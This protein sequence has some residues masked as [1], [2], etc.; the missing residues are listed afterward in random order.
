MS[1]SRKAY[2]YGQGQLARRSF[3]DS[4]RMSTVAKTIAKRSPTIAERSDCVPNLS[5]NDQSLFLA[6]V[7]LTFANVDCRRNDRQKEW[8]SLFYKL[9]TQSAR[10]GNVGESW[11]SRTFAE[12]SPSKL[13][14]TEEPQCFTCKDSVFS[15]FIK[16]KG[17]WNLTFSPGVWKC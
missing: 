1:S 2:Y 3:G 7:R 8:W 11:H 12:R 17:I 6:I 5:F 4:S 16:L 9:R 14:L 15:H 10:S 13:S